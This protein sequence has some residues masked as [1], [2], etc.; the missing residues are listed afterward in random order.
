MIQI[1]ILAVAFLL[2][3]LIS[4]LALRGMKIQT[5]LFKVILIHGIIFVL[6]LVY[7]SR[8]RE[9]ALLGPAI[10]WTGAFLS[11]FGARS[12]V[13]SSILL[14]MLFLLRANPLTASRLLSEYEADYGESLRIEELARTGLI[15][16][17]PNG[18]RV[19]R[20]G[21]WILNAVGRLK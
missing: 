2:A 20:K 11:W 3:V 13:E 1:L 12:H 16:Q 15:V 18:V 9:T 7:L 19:T 21:R 4:E 10:F 5:G 6:T 8:S 14:R 17:G